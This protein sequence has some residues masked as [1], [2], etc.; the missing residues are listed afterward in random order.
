MSCAKKKE[1]YGQGIFVQG[2]DACLQRKLNT[3][4]QGKDEKGRLG[5]IVEGPQG[6]Q[7]SGPF[8][9]SNGKLQKSFYQ[10]NDLI[11]VTI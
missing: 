2:V 5:P 4:E 8:S 7:E 6:H 11:K 1:Y 10:R 9:V 3:V